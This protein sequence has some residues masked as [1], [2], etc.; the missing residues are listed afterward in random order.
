MGSTKLFVGSLPPNIDDATFAQ[1]FQSYGQIMSL[2]CNQ[3]KRYGF[4]TYSSMEEAQ[5]AINATNGLAVN[6][7]CIVVKFAQNQNAGGGGAPPAGAMMLGAP[8]PGGVL[9][10]DRLYIKGLPAGMTDDFVRGIFDAYGT[11]LDSKVLV[12]NG[13][14]DDGSGQSVAIVKMGSV[15]EA[16]WLV[17]NVNGNIPQGLAGPVQIAFAGPRGSTGASNRYV[18]YAA[19]APGPPA[20]A[21]CLQAPMQL[22]AQLGGKGGPGSD[23]LVPNIKAMMAESGPNSTLYVKNLPLHADDLYLYKAFAPFGCVLNVKALPKD[24]FVIG[25]V[26]YA[27]DSEAEGAIFALNGQALAD[28]TVLHVSVKTSR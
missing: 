26:Q 22:Q 18:P 6:G 4:V 17:E 10:Q 9:P 3:D 25:F 14:S 20:A 7:C 28:G 27:S 19:A 23:G 12:A 5:E 24:G 11:V 13:K 16:T 21:P 15:A 1:L 8:Q 2:V